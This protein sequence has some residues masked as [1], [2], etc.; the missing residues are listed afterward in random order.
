LRE[1]FGC[2]PFSTGYFCNVDCL[3]AVAR[4]PAVHEDVQHCDQWQTCTLLEKIEVLGLLYLLSVW[5]KPLV[6]NA[7]LPMWIEQ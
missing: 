7:C 5:T 1:V 3:V 2:L 4:F 6:G